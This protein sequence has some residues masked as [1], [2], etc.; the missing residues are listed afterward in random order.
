MATNQ[1]PQ[2]IGETLYLLS[3]QPLAL[4]SYHPVLAMEARESGA[5]QKAH[6]LIAEFRS[7]F[8][9]IG[10]T[11][12]PAGIEGEAAGKSS[13]LAWAVRQAWNELKEDGDVERVS[14]IV[15]TVIDSDSTFTF[16]FRSYIIPITFAIITGERRS[17]LS[18]S[19][20]P[21]H[22]CIS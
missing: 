15:V 18:D 17:D 13:N 9:D 16:D 2:F 8:K 3:S 21:K 4:T 11:L 20:D 19:R 6:Q 22:P 5:A 7:S 1:D 12:H 14:K 10:Y